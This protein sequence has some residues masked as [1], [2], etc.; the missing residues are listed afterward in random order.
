[1]SAR[2]IGVSVGRGSE[3]VSLA[4][5]RLVCSRA[6]IGS[7]DGIGTVGFR[8]GAGFDG[9]FER[10]VDETRMMFDVVSSVGGIVGSG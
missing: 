1:M 7:F 6:G 9:G 5:R 8:D 4:C 10:V 2:S 3:G